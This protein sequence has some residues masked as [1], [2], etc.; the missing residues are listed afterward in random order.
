MEKKKASEKHIDVLKKTSDKRGVFGF[1][2]TVIRSFRFLSFLAF[3]L[4][5]SGLYL[6]CL[7][8]ALFPVVWGVLWIYEL[9]LSLP[10]WLR[11][12]TLSG[13]LAVAF[14]IFGVTLILVVPLLNWPLLRFVK[15]QRGSWFS[16]ETI[17]WYVHNALVQLVRFTVLDLFTPT[18]L[19]VI[20]FRLMGTLSHHLRG[21][22]HHWGLGDPI[23]PLWYEG[24]SDH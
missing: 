17:P 23:C 12:L 4:P 11:A 18:P 19:N 24:F 13:T 10:L 20:F 16:I 2:E 21:P 1:F 22:R 7:T 15:P 6:L 5:L 3:L 8:S 9:S 14:L